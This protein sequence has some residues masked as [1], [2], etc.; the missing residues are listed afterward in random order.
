[1]LSKF[2]ENGNRIDLQSLDRWKGG[3]EITPKVYQSRVIDILSEDTLEIE[4]PLEQSKLVLLPIDSEYEM[5]FY[6][7]SG[8][9]Q[10]YARITDR[11]KSNNVYMLVMELISDLSK[12]QRRE[13]YRFSCAIEMQV[14]A[15]TKDEVRPIE[16]N[17]PYRIQL[18]LAM[19]EGIIVDISGGGIRFMSKENFE[20]GSLIFCS[21]PL[22]IGSTRKQFEVLGKILSVK[23]PENKPG[24][25]EY[26]ME[27]FRLNVNARE[28]IIKY[29]FEEE[30]KSRKKERLS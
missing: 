17:E 24:Y 18:G 15:L 13:Y 20:A 21:Y 16:N 14:R 30:R 11:Y 23:K 4:M 10:C 27:Y 3:E 6:G 1:M 22:Q 19:Q 7:K 2:I 26:R 25:L 8:L 29:I 12:Y 28:E 5:I 9:Y